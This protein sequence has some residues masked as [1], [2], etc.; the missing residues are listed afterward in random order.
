MLMLKT[1]KLSLILFVFTSSCVTIP[2]TEHC[3]VKGA[4]EAGAEC[5]YSLSDEVVNMTPKEFIEFLEP[6]PG[7]A[8]AVCS[9]ASDFAAD[10]TALEQACSLLGPRCKHSNLPSRIEYLKKKFTLISSDI[11]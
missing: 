1:K 7:K 9:P 8:A 2:N 6:S 10:L 4:I 3:H 5:G 11:K